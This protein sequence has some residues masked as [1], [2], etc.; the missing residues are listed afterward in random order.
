MK[1]TGSVKVEI[2]A[3]GDELIFGRIVDT[4]S[5]W[6][7]KRV[8]EIGARLRRV[9]MIGDE[10]ELIDS[11]LQDA[12]KRDAHFIIFSGGLGP[13]ADDITVDS[14][15]TSLGQDTVIDE[16]GAAKIEAVYRKRGITEQAS[17]DRGRRMARILKGSIAMQ[18]PVGFAVGMEVEV[19][20]KTIC[21]LPGVPSE[22]KGMFDAHVAPLIM[23]QTNTVFVAR[24]FNISMIWKDFFPLYRQMQIDYPEIYIKNAATPPV[25]DSDRSN[26]HT[27]KV[28]FV[29]EA[30]TSEIAEKT[31]KDFLADYMKRIDKIGG[32][33]MLLIRS[34]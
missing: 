16:E 26:V 19:G 6:I 11:A 2:I 24:T 30:E 9:T 12:L 22:L 4:N 31:M 15:G 17:I 8:A 25:E 21:T 34:S 20:G 3:T 10:P 13:S 5:N 27:I 32:G 18:N 33:E 14:I 7:A 1:P 28:D 23:N 29:L